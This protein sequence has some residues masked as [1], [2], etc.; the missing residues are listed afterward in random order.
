[1]ETLFFIFTH[2]A[3]VL[4]IINGKKFDM[5]KSLILRHPEQVV[6]SPSALSLIISFK[7]VHQATVR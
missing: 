7:I 4:N 5:V 1:M 6:A 3:M 2:Q